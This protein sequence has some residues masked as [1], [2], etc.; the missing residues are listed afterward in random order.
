MGLK[1]S[2]SLFFFFFFFGLHHGL[3]AACEI[4]WLRDVNSASACGGSNP[5]IR[6]RTQGPRT[7]SA[8]P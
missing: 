3:V 4:F 1:I 2:P 5:L 8:E 7:G 6:D